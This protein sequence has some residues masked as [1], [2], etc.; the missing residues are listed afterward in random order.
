MIVTDIGL[1]SV[2]IGCVPGKL[3]LPAG[4]TETI[5]KT[6]MKLTIPVA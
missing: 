1:D 4:L 2:S 3:R 5:P 6:G